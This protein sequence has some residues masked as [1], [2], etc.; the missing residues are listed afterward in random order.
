MAIGMQ[1]S[2]VDQGRWGMLGLCLI[3][4]VRGHGD[5]GTYLGRVRH[6]EQ[7]SW[8]LKASAVG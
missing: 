8:N 6:R 3:T 2:T 1:C 5:G 4:L 7:P